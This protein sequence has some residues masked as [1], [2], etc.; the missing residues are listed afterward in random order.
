M[1]LYGGHCITEIIREL[2]GAVWRT[3]Y[4]KNYTRILWSCFEET[5]AQKLYMDF[6]QWSRVHCTTKIIHGLYW[7]CIE[8]IVSQKFYM[9][10]MELFGG[11]C[12]T[13]I[14][15]GLYW[16]C[17][18]Y[19]VITKIIHGLYGAVSRT[20][21]HKTLYT[22]F[23]QLLQGQQNTKSICS[24]SVPRVKSSTHK[25]AVV[26]KQMCQYLTSG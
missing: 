17:F 6:M 16:S 26:S 24:I 3:L 15:Q 21:Y 25:K 19:T 14:I 13:K 5:V 10:F 4:H 23:M 22:N 8:D 18:G 20:L 11:H 7:S 2:Y 9:D 1:E 12:I